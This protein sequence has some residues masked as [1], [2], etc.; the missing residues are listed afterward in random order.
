MKGLE[1]LDLVFGLVFIY[2]IYSIACSTI[3]E[4]FA[5]LL[6]LRG[7]ALQKW[8]RKNFDNKVP[9]EGTD[10]EN[11]NAEKLGDKILKHPLIQGLTNTKKRIPSYIP[12]WVFSDVLIDLLIND[13]S[14]KSKTG[15]PPDINS[16]K[17]KL[18]NTTILSEGLKRVFLQYLSDTG[19]LQLAKD[20]IS[21]WFEDAQERLI[22]N[23]KK[24]LQIWIMGIAMVL[25]GFTNADTINLA[26]FL[27]NNDNARE[28]VAKKADLF[29]QDSAIINKVKEIRT[30]SPDSLK[31]LSQKVIAARL[32]ENV[33]TLKN[34]NG[35]LNDLKLPLGWSIEK[36]KPFVLWWY[37]KKIGGLLLTALAVSMGAP[38]WFDV[39]NKIASLRSSGNKP[40]TLQEEKD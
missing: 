9:I 18:G 7:K 11:P 35:E 5:N 21:K 28:A 20:K 13:K 34:L 1:F 12:S 37:L 40:K 10:A 17:E 15:L 26:T 22:G 8:L 36:D 3:W 32:D 16:L 30:Y 29:L 23:Y 4:T 2:L 6:L 33:N 39:L 38:F 24:H 25:V 19:D 14:E 27:Y 31:G